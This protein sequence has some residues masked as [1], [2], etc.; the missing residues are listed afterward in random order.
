[1]VN[2]A[3]F[4]IR[5]HELKRTAGQYQLKPELTPVAFHSFTLYDS[6]H[7]SYLMFRPSSVGMPSVVTCHELFSAP[8]V[9][10]SDGSK[11]SEL[12]LTLVPDMN[13]M[14]H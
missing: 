4:D 13:G 12:P 1:M 6:S 11:K 3:A 7:P 5:I 10:K 2:P 9:S 8:L 14:Y